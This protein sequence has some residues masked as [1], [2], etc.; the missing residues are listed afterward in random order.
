MNKNILPIVLF[1]FILANSVHA[2]SEFYDEVLTRPRTTSFNY[3]NVG[4]GPLLLIPNVG[5]G[6]RYYQD[7]FGF[8]VSLN[9][10]SVYYVSSLQLIA[11]ALYIPNPHVERPW[12]FGLGGALGVGTDYKFSGAIVTASPNFLIGKELTNN[13]D[14]KSFVEAQIQFPTWGSKARKISKN[15]RVDFPLMYVKYGRSF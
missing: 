12:Y 10:G 5:I 2:Q 15:L 4:V 6:H 8:D 13:N 3:W 1:F 9:F 11:N 7:Q 14:Y